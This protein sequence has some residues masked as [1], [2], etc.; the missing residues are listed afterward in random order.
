MFDCY[1][2]LYICFRMRFSKSNTANPAVAIHTLN[3]YDVN[4]TIFR[5]SFRPTH[6][7]TVAFCSLYTLDAAQVLPENSKH[8]ALLI[9][10]IFGLKRSYYWKLKLKLIETYSICGKFGSGTYSSMNFEK[11]R[12]TF[13]YSH[14]L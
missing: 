8:S 5:I 12:F 14:F 13:C 2:M 7:Y 3:E 10:R 1:S 4:L 11:F 9:T 6:T